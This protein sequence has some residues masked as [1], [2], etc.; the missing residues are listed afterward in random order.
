MAFSIGQRVR[1]TLNGVECEVLAVYPE[2]HR[3]HLKVVEGA[4]KGQELQEV[5]FHHIAEIAPQTV[6]A[7]DPPSDPVPGPIDASEGEPG[8][9][10]PG[11]T[12][13]TGG[14]QTPGRFSRR[15]RGE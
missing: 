4:A 10:D 3:V 8:T 5:A 1:Y 12:G 14:L 11:E 2:R 15:L 7:P 6:T 13:R 9:A